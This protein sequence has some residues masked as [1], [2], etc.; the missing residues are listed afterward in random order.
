MGVIFAIGLLSS[1]AL[2]ALFPTAAAAG[3]SADPI[4]VEDPH[5]GEVLY[6]FYQQDYFPAIVRV[7]AGQ[8][9]R[10][11]EEHAD[12]AELLLGGMYLSFGQHLEAADIFDRL[13]ANNTA[14]DIRDRTWFFLA[15]IWYQR[16]Y[17]GK[18]QQAL[19]NIG[20]ALPDELAREALMLDAQILI[21]A[22]D[23]D[24]AIAR[25]WNWQGKTEWA[26]YA[27][28]NLGVALV[29]SGRVDDAGLIVQ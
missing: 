27:A 20:G 18:A 7:L 9:Q 12:E 23:H 1:Q 10:Q 24:A 14:P 8:E 11:L 3:N 22:G 15:K 4:V 21:D 25:L 19:A 17:P 16:G 26:S 13:L 28:F 29:R 6:Y 2:L 5:F